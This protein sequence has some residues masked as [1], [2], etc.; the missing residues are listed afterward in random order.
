LIEAVT[1]R[2]RGHSISDPGLYRTKEALKETMEKDPIMR[3]QKVLIEKGILTEAE[4]EEMDKEM[5]DLVIAS[6]K[7]ADESPWPDPITLEE[8]VFAPW[9]KN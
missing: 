1:E 8:G 9:E 6:M 4:C 5:K 7:F 3:F 2:F